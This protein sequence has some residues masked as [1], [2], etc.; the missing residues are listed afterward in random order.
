MTMA[1]NY[2]YVVRVDGREVW[3]GKQPKEK[4]IEM[5]K[6][7][8]MKRVSVAWQSDDDLLVICIG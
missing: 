3:R 8:P 5:K 4:L 7:N 6:K 1:R 2:W